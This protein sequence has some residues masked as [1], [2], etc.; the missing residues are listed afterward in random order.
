MEVIVIIT[1]F[2]TISKISI[3]ENENKYSMERL[4]A[5]LQ[6][7]GIRPSAQRIAVLSWIAG[8]GKHPSAEEIYIGLSEVFSTL[9]RTTVYNSLKILVDKKLLR[10][11]EVESGCLRYDMLLEPHGHFVCRGCGRIFDMP[12][13][14]GVGGVA[15][16]QFQID[17]VEVTFRG[18]CPVCINN[19]TSTNINTKQ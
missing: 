17:A 19:N 2:V 8:S 16:P 9:S 18:L 1:N 5:I 14:A 6:E 10:E 13:P 4:A 3:M 11:L 15:A 7:K 12:M